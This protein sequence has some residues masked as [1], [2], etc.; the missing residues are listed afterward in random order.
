[1]L[2][3]TLVSV[4][5][6]DDNETN[7]HRNEDKAR[8]QDAI[9]QPLIVEAEI[10]VQD[11]EGLVLLVKDLEVANDLCVGIVEQLDGDLLVGWVVE[12]ELGWVDGGWWWGRHGSR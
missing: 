11:T 3:F 9:L 5:E 6:H 10:R 8:D 1:M 7:C 4:I 2:H 12:V